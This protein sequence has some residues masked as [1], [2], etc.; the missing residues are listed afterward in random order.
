M[1]RSHLSTCC[2][3]SLGREWMENNNNEIYVNHPNFG[4]L[5]RICALEESRELYTTLYAQR[6]FFLATG[7]GSSQAF[8]P[9]GRSDARL[10]VE[11]RLR[12]LRREAKTG[13]R[14]FQDL[15]AV[16]KRIFQ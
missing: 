7:P 2:D 12:Q 16:H 5:Y 8:E 6:L 9:M 14:E 4:L 3:R 10:L 15:S 11:G 1:L 13:E